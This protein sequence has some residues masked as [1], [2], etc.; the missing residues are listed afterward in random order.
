MA[1]WRVVPG[2]RGDPLPLVEALD[3][4][5]GEPSVHDL[6]HKRKRDG[7]VM[8]VELDVVVDVDA[9]RLPLPVD[10]G[11]DGQRTEG[12]TIQSLEERT[13]ARLVL[14][15]HAAVEVR[16]QVADA[17]VQRGQ[18]E[19]RLM[20]EP[21]QDPALGH[22]HRR[23]DFRFVPSPP[24]PGRQD[25]GADMLG[26]LLDMLCKTYRRVCAG[27]TY[28]AEPAEPLGTSSS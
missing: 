13:P 14:P 10:E 19:E 21:R 1:A 15:H 16:E 4:R 24:G 23:L 26:E 28:V 12:G 18:R 8:P 9:R 5:G 3:G 27:Q 20:P 17:R 11:L 2:M 7:V 25:H 6:V 22:Q